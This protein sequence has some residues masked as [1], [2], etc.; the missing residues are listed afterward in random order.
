MDEISEII[1]GIDFGTTNTVVSYFENNKSN[2]LIDGVYKSIPSKIGIKNN[3][4]Y[5]GNY[6]PLQ[7]DKIIHSFKTIIGT[8]MGPIIIGNK[9]LEINDILIIFFEHIKKIIYKKF[10]KNILIKSIITVPSNFNDKQREIIRNAFNNVNFNVLR[11]INEPSA[12]SLAYGLNNI[13][14]E[15]E[16]IL[17]IDTGGGTMDLTVLIKENGFFEIEN[18]IGLNDL[19]GNNFTDCI[20][21]YIKS[22]IDNDNINNN[23]IILWNLCQIAK[24]KLTWVE[25]Y[26]IKYNNQL[27]NITQKHFEKLINNLINKIEDTFNIIKSYNDKFNHIILVG[28]T[29]KIPI[30]QRIIEETFKIKP[31]IH[32]NL[33]SVVSEG[34][35]LYG[36]ISENKYETNNNVVLVDVVPL[37]LGIETSEGNFSIIIPKNTP[38]PAKK[39]ARYTTDT[40]SENSVMVK[41]YQGERKIANKN[42]LIGEYL[43]NKISTGGTPIIDITFKVD[44]NG[45]INI[46][47]LDKKSMIEKNILIKEIPKYNT[48]QIEEILFDAEN[49][50]LID[51]E[52]M[53]K[54]TRLYIITTK[55]EIIMNNIKFN[56]LIT[57][58]KKQ[59]L[60][61]K[62]INY[63][64]Q[65]NYA[66]TTE[67]LDII[68]QINDDFSTFSSNNNDEQDYNKTNYDELDKYILQELKEDLETKI[69]LLLAKNPEW[70][71][72]LQ[73][74]L[75]DIQFNNITKEYL[76]DKLNIIKDLEDD[77]NQIT[78]YKEQYNNLCLF[79]KNE[80]T[81]GNIVLENNKMNE[82]QDLINNSLNLLNDN[83]S[84]NINW[85]ELLYLFNKKCE[86]IYN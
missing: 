43:F 28:N 65:I 18:S 84:D 7:P 77:N 46:I 17:V 80:I 36:A 50:E 74:I 16:R 5:C 71:E 53:I 70:E 66:S 29:S 82:L 81:N 63:E 19:G 54:K 44:L 69:K 15:E 58:E 39:T 61:N 3:N 45:I 47:I 14:D 41:V 72:Y 83:T 21:N 1:F 8:E 86:E 56:N 57:E 51:E 9:K 73:P 76:E 6:I 13:N 30:L 35:C 40:P 60:Y 27:F 24:E 59:E 52:E 22:L 33:E 62:L 20:F 38:L 37:S 34:A 55:I 26:E 85:E 78:N 79:I 2:L 11:I 23:E 64:N 32:P 12:A 48:E 10:G 68:R 4:F 25:S 67:L 42:I 75:D 49:N 31:W